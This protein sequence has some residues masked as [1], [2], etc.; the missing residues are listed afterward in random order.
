MKIISICLLLLIL[1][2]CQIQVAD[3]DKKSDD[4][5]VNNNQLSTTIEKNINFIS[6]HDKNSNVVPLIRPLNSVL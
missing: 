2:G 4:N 1:T 6:V 3:S 5:V